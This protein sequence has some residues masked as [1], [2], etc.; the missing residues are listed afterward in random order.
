MK[1][2]GKNIS[3]DEFKLFV[4]LTG[5]KEGALEGLTEF[6]TLDKAAKDKKIVLNEENQALVD[7]YVDVIKDEYIAP[8]EIKNISDER[9]KS[10]LSFLTQVINGELMEKI[11]VEKNYKFDEAVLATE[12]EGYRA[13][14]KFIKYI[15]TN[16]R[17]EAKD[18]LNL[19]SSDSITIDEAIKL[20]SVLHDESQG[21]EKIDLSELM[22]NLY[23]QY[24][25]MLID[26]DYNKVMELKASEISEEFN[27]GIIIIFITAT[28]EEAVEYF[29]NNYEGEEADFE[30]ELANYYLNNKLLKYIVAETQEKAEEARKALLDGLDPEE[31]IKKY[32][33]YYDESAGIEKV[34]LSWMGFSEEE[35]AKIMA[36]QESEFSEIIEFGPFIIFIE[37]TSKE[38]ED[39]VKDESEYSQKYSLYEEEYNS[40]KEKAKIKVNDKLFDEFDA[41]AYLQ[42]VYGGY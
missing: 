3:M 2:E 38:T 25:L 34:E 12:V 17:Q 24:G 13:R 37:T 20:Y 6:L 40:W 5:S 7:S 11:A 21:I 22:N 14:D 9:I 26:N 32:S 15:I 39:R 30:T 33:I 35:N 10:I 18:V 19:L 8:G 16:K 23:S 4:L 28:D 42:S 36:L 29:R 1:F 41:D 31:A 27:L